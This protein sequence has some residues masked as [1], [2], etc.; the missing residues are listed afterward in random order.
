[1]FLRKLLLFAMFIVPMTE[2]FVF[3]LVG[4]WIGAFP[5]LLIAILTSLLG[6]Y[7]LRREGTHTYQLAQIQLQNGHLPGRAI[8]D[9]VLIMIG[10]YL[11]IIPGFITDIFG[12][13]CILPC[14]RN[15]L[16]FWL[17]IWLQRRIANGNYVFRR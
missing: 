7:L 2:I 12:L 14:T 16:L 13:L 15:I 1:M 11:L 8:L 9:G 5:T 10:G 3:I 4:K 6:L 17:L